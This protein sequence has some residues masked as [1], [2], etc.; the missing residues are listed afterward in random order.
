MQTW[1]VVFLLAQGISLAELV[2]TLQIVN[3]IVDVSTS[4]CRFVA[5]KEQDQSY[6]CTPWMPRGE[7]PVY[8]RER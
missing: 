7:R 2:Q 6:V 5:S 8:S 1:Q 4:V 3:K